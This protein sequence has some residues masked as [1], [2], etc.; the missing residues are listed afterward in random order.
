MRRLTL[1]T[2][3]SYSYFFS[4]AQSYS[5]ITSGITSPVG[6]N[7]DS[8]GNLWVA[9]PGTG[10]N[11]GKIFMI[12]SLNNMHAAVKGLPS[13]YDSVKQNISG[14]WR[15]IPLP[16]KQLMVVVGGGPDANAGSLLI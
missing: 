14:P 13:H 15:G 9:S 1:L 16:G 12:D 2:F 7:K 11:D 10:M 4:A 8:K 5:V 3:L 6:I